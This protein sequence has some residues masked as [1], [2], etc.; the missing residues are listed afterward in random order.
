MS[1]R[2]TTEE[3]IA[4][5]KAVHGDKYDYSKTDYVSSKNKITITC[6]NHGDFTQ[7]PDAHLVGG[8][9]LCGRESRKIK[10]CSLIDCFNKVHNYRYDYSLVDGEV[11][12]ENIKIICREHGIFMQRRSHHMSG[13]GCPLCSKNR[14]LTFDI[15]LKKSN[16]V[17]SFYYQYDEGSFVNSMVKAKIICR[18]HGEFFQFTSDHMSGKGCP[19][20]AEYG[21]KRTKKKAYVYFLESVSAGAV[22]IGVTHN[23]SERIR[24]LI[25]ST[26]FQFDVI[27]IVKISGF[28]AAKIESHFHKKFK[29]AGFSGFD[30]CTEW[31]MKTPL[32]MEEIEK[33]TPQ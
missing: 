19:E 14:R 28:N 3:F 23:K 13:S 33:L 25:K 16:E 20:C 6:K 4:K 31:V 7:R 29:N 11:S 17:H 10:L 27:K 12:S 18:K 21:F 15:F 8:C 22:K 5:A 30:G 2:L 32:L 26:P 1:K 24:K 9:R